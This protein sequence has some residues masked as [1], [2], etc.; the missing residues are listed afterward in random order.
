MSRPAQTSL[1]PETTPY[2]CGIVVNHEVYLEDAEWLAAYDLDAGEPETALPA[3]LQWIRAGLARADVSARV[4]AAPCVAINSNT[5]HLLQQAW[6]R[7]AFVGS[8]Q[9]VPDWPTVFHIPFNSRE[10]PLQPGFPDTFL[11]HL[12]LVGQL[13][14]SAT[15]IHPP[16][17][18]G[19]VT[20]A[21]VELF[22][23][24]AIRD[25]ILSAKVLVCIE[26]A[27]NKNTF[28]QN[29]EHLVK[30]RQAVV[31]RVPELA[32][33]LKFCFDTGHYLLYQ[34]RDGGPDTDWSEWAGPFLAE[35]C[36]VHVQ[37]ND[38]SRDQ[39]LLPLPALPEASS[40]PTT[41]DGPKFARNCAHVLAW[42]RE[43]DQVWR[44]SPVPRHLVLEINPVLTGALFTQYW[45]Q[46]A[47]IL[48][49]GRE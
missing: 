37:A 30:L 41:V 13:G 6:F 3:V 33:F 36:V 29:F 27:E 14:A 40:F 25:A 19:D 7:D 26:N 35:T 15:V 21:L 24:P 39:H 12:E 34:Q 23:K 2:R 42:F 38:G 46:W 44:A 45:R 1:V 16:K 17:S 18:P 10:L 48:V 47:E 32:P 28:Y 11:A 22:A 20:P 4:G 5:H 8:L 31:Q 49:A 43:A 9:A